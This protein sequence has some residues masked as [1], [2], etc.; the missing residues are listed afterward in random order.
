M[1]QDFDWET[2]TEYWYREFKCGLKFEKFSCCYKCHMPL[3]ICRSGSTSL[4]YCSGR[5]KDILL[6]LLLFLF[7]SPSEYQCLAQHIELEN[8]ANTASLKRWASRKAQW[9]GLECSNLWVRVIDKTPA[10]M[11]A[12][13][14]GSDQSRSLLDYLIRACLTYLNRVCLRHLCSQPPKNSAS[15]QQHISP[16]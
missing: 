5:H 14:R 13:K 8:M 3:Q 7:K 16:V 11:L 9:N 10:F 1:I 4:S 12:E 6:P 15:F 2:I